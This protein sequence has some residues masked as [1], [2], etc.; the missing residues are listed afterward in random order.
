MAAP[1]LAGV[2]RVA[3]VAGRQLATAEASSPGRFRQALDYIKRATGGQVSTAAQAAKYAEGSRTQNALVVRGMVK[4]GFNPDEIITREILSEVHDA[5]LKSF[6]E[7]MRREFARDYGA[8]DA[9]SAIKADDS[10]QA[11]EIATMSAIN[12]I[13][14]IFNL[15]WG[16]DDAVI[17]LHYSLRRF[18]ATDDALVQRALVMRKAARPR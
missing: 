4:A 10:D 2:A 17:R 12:D 18:L 5:Q 15:P 14:R 7:S 9:A 1:A 16:S 13:E 8:V 11:P 6:Y 3:M